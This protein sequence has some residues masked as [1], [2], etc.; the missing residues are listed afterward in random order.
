MGYHGIMG[1]WFIESQRFWV[2]WP[3]MTEDFI[4]GILFIWENIQRE[5]YK[6]Y[7]MILTKHDTIIMDIMG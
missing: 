1:V 2:Y 4:I 3:I 6:L 5:Y 7:P